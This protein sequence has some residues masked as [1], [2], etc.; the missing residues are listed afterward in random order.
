MKIPFTQLTVEAVPE[1][2]K[3]F[4]FSTAKVQ[5]FFGSA[6]LLWTTMPEQYQNALLAG[7]GLT[8]DRM[9]Q[10]SALMWVLS[11]LT[12]RRTKVVRN[13]PDIDST[14]EGMQP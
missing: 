3:I 4:G 13:E 11:T 2:N 8:P 5:Y 6:V 1:G 10:I 7:V 9:L 12:A 14:A